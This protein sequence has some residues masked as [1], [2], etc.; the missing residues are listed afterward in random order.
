MKEALT[1]IAA[2]LRR[3]ADHMTRE[4]SKEARA[5]QRRIAQ[6]TTKLQLGTDPRFPDLST[7]AAKGGF[8]FTVEMVEAVAECCDPMAVCN[9][10]LDRPALVERIAQLDA[11]AIKT[12]ILAVEEQMGNAG[13]VVVAFNPA[14]GPAGRPR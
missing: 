13:D 6:F 4:E 10:L 12:E 5:K 14:A 7:K 9:Y 2:Q 8:F 1:E 3:I 11:E